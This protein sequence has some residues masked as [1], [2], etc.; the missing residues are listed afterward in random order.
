MLLKS[1]KSAGWNIELP[2]RRSFSMRAPRSVRKRSRGA[3][4]WARKLV[5]PARRT[6]S[7]SAFPGRTEDPLGASLVVGADVIQISVIGEG[8][9]GD[10]VN[11]P[12]VKLRIQPVRRVGE[13]FLQRSWVGANRPVRAAKEHGIPGHGRIWLAAGVFGAGATGVSAPGSNMSC[14]NQY[15]K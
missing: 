15:P 10:D 7:H 9:L 4:I 14:P 5:R 12:P 2:A 11:V 8:V 3:A 6:W 13:A 1:V